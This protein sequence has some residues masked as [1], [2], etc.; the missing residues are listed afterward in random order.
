MQALEFEEKPSKVLFGGDSETVLA[1]REKGCGALGEYFG[2]R[3]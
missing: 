1:A 2:N 3:I